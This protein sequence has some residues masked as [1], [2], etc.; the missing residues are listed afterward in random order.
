[1][2]DNAPTEDKWSTL[3]LKCLKFFK[4]KDGG[5]GT[6]HEFLVGELVN[7]E[8][9]EGENFW[10]MERWGNEKDAA[11]PRLNWDTILEYLGRYQ[12]EQLNSWAG[13]VSQPHNLL[14]RANDGVAF[15]SKL[16]SSSSETRRYSHDALQTCTN[17]HQITH[18]EGD[19]V[20][21]EPEAEIY[22]SE[23]VNPLKLLVLASCIQTVA[24]DYSLLGYN[25]YFFT[26]VV[27]VLAEELFA[28]REMTRE[29]G[30]TMGKVFGLLELHSLQGLNFKAKLEEVRVLY[31]QKWKAIEENVSFRPINSLND[32]LNAYSAS[33]RIRRH[34]PI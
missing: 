31:R 3:R 10:R 17:L 16:A 19:N 30:S 25:C 8:T 12:S 28:G 1:M 15:A 4:N 13:P 23:H 24:P 18:R 14:P 9:D 11:Q 22:F 2:K 7:S 27:S 29:A 20:G 26:R 6:C 21:D 34:L 32:I 33:G 5:L